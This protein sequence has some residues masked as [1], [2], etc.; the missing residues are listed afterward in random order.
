MNE[1]AIRLSHTTISTILV[2]RRKT[3]PNPLAKKQ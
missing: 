1:P 2:Y 3:T